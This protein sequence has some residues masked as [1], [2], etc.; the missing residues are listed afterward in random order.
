MIYLH[1]V[2]IRID[3]LF[4]IYALLPL[5]GPLFWIITVCVWVNRFFF[6]KFLLN[7]FFF[8]IKNKNQPIPI[9]PSRSNRTAIG[10]KTDPNWYALVS[11]ITK[12]I[13]IGSVTNL[14]KKTEFTEP[15]TPLV[16]VQ[17]KT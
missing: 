11:I 7:R 1:T 2:Q 3:L 12:P 16:I 10:W 15:C 13:P 5:F 14:K 9:K 8:F 4:T 6:I 17:L